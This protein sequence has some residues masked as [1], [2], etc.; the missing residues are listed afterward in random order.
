MDKTIGV[1]CLIV[2]MAVMLVIGL[3]DNGIHSMLAFIGLMLGIAVVYFCERG[4]DDR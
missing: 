3:S 2:F 1:I 4:H